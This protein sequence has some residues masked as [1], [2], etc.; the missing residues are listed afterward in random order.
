MEGFQLYR[1]DRDQ[2]QKGG[3]AL[4]L[5]ADIAAETIEL[6]KVSDGYIEHL[7]M[8]I[9]KYNLVVANVHNPPGTDPTKLTTVMNL[10]ENRDNSYPSEDLE[11]YVT[12]DEKVQKI[13]VE[14]L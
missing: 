3:V 6:S 13:L 9:K 7:M 2:R 4:Y 11:V 12:C 5:R 8:H 1:A 14:Y 10:I